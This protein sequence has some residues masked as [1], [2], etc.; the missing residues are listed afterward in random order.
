MEKQRLTTFVISLKNLSK[1]TFR[2]KSLIAIVA[3]FAFTI[4]CGALLSQSLSLGRNYMSGRMGA[5]I[6]V[7]PRGCA[8]SLQDTLLRSKSNTFY[9]S[10]NL[11]EEISKMPGVEQVSPQLYIG[12]LNASCCTVPVQ[13]IGFEPKTDFTIKSWM[14]NISSSKLGFGEVVTGSRVNAT[15]GDQVWF[16]GQ[17]LKVVAT[18]DDTGM[19]FDSSVFMTLETAHH[20]M[21]ISEQKSVHPAGTGNDHLSALFIKVAGDADASEVAK[22]IMSAYPQTDV[23]VLKE[24]MQHLSTQLNNLKALIY[25]IQGLLW[26]VSILILAV[27]FTVTTNER[28]REFGLFLALGATQKKLESLLMTET[29]IISGSG[30]LCGIL[31]ACFIMFEFRMLIA[32]SLGLPYLQPTIGST[33][34]LAAISLLISVF[35]GVIACVY[36]VT[37]IVRLETDLMIREYV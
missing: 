2:T 18:L 17:P 30:A 10:E 7:V 35:T 1:H 11:A 21:E 3:V 23:V 36:S 5:D 26:I 33:I 27:V 22:T 16:F 34:I 13:L 8:L 20:M 15:L 12:S 31:A 29:L 25:G 14:T 19:G 24:M 4:F 37:R 32:I 9:M 6:M 28:K